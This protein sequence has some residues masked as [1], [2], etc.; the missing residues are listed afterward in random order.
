MIYSL[1]YRE[2]VCVLKGGGG[3]TVV[4]VVLAFGGN[5]MWSSPVAITAQKD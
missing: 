4:V 2:S 1:Q 3:G 5:G